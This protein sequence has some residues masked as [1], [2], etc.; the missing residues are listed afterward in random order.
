MPTVRSALHHAV[1]ATGDGMAL[2]GFDWAVLVLTLAVPITVGIAYGR[3]AG[4]NLS[5]FFLSGR[6]LPWWLA[7]TSMVA[8]TFAAD[9]PLAVTGIV[10]ASGVAG[11][12]LW[13]N[14]ALGSVLTVTF[15][16]R[17][18]RR[19]GILTDVEFVEL[20]YTGRSAR[21]LRVVRALYLGLP[22]NC[23]IIGWVN[24]ALAKVLS[25]SLGWN[26][27]TGV[28]VGL[29]ATGGYAALTGLRGVVAA[30]LVQ[31]A[32]A[33][34]GA[35][36][37]AWYAL[38][39]PGVGGVAGLQAALPESTFRL[40]PA[41]GSS[42]VPTADAATTLA[43]PV[44]AFVAYLGVQWWASWYPGQEPGGGGYVAQR[45]MSARSER[46]AVLS[47]LWFTVAHYC[48]RP[49]P[50]VLVALVS[51]VLYPD[52]ADRE[53][54]YVLVLRDHL[55]NGWRGLLVGAFFAAYMSTVS[56]QLNWGTSYLVNDVY[57]RFMRP[58]AGE[59]HLV[60]V[61]RLTTIGIML[62]S[63]LITFWLESVRQAWEFVL[64]SGAGLGLVL[65]LRWYWW[66][67]TAVSEL[68]AMAAAA[69]GFVFVRG[70][71]TVPFPD[72]LL[73]LVPWTTACWVVATL[74]TPAE[75]MVHLVRFY[76]RTHPDGPGWSSVA[77]AAGES[78]PAS[79]RPH[80]RCWAAGCGAVYL[81]LAA[82][83]Q[84]LFG[85]PVRAGLLFACALALAVWLLKK[86]GRD[87]EAGCGGAE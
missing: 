21:V 2:T 72:S 29:A 15:F 14:A 49:W 19:A 76:R 42:G 6:N 40:W 51:L 78:P 74:A 65:I 32:I 73:Y 8:T 10:A 43:L 46:D 68:V 7:G 58:D 3:R 66:R 45:M 50:W 12:W 87:T 31:F 23:L 54:G 22:V 61:A 52:L 79:L 57:K 36:V 56:T 62:L 24:L 80:A 13:W 37:L 16:A 67:V 4:R 30:D 38:S 17:L 1:M 27:L 70:F 59:T 64:E 82:T 55:P 11:N 69:A 75:P 83:H 18:W 85:T 41:V 81:T 34:L 60:V 35:V 20:R 53:A 26:R 39:A 33:L 28:L 47:T 84:M 71:T 9:T 86:L 5:Q 63:G 48:L 77:A 25:V 44:A